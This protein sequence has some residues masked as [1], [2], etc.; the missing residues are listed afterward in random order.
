MESELDAVKAYFA[1]I[2]LQAD[3][4]LSQAAN[5]AADKY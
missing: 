5:T 4:K 3:Q 2:W 1:H